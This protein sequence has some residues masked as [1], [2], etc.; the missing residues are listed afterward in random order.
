MPGHDA[1]LTPYKQAP[2]PGMIMSDE[3]FED[4]VKMVL[5]M[6][7]MWIRNRFESDT[8]YTE[9]GEFYETENEL[10][11]SLTDIIGWLAKIC[12]HQMEKSNAI[13]EFIPFIKE[14][15]RNSLLKI[16]AQGLG[17]VNDYSPL[18]NM[19]VQCTLDILECCNVLGAN[20]YNE[21]FCEAIL[22]FYALD[23]D[24][25]QMCVH[26]IGVCAMHAPDEFNANVP[27]ATAVLYT[28]LQWSPEGSFPLADSSDEYLQ[29]IQDL[30]AIAL[31]KLCIYRRDQM[32]PAGGVDQ[33]LPR[34]LE[35]LPIG[36]GED[37]ALDTRIFHRMFISLVASQ[38][39]RLLGASG[40][41]M[42]EV[43]RILKELKDSVEPNEAD[44]LMNHRFKDPNIDTSPSRAVDFWKEQLICDKS[45]SA[46]LELFKITGS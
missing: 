2:P 14:I 37:E 44:L 38:D 33:I 42:T 10:W 40:E 32:D 45:Y 8:D 23:E 35:L 12:P 27:R 21:P 22:Q 6:S 3:I 11:M 31:F 4:V 30:A 39:A 36:L 19:S 29:K 20:A 26:A 43:L 46:I 13:I 15:L 24:T 17:V 7:G 18:I 5:A 1:I 16:S 41:R 34:V 28:F 9:R 25:A